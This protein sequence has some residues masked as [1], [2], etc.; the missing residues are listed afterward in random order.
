MLDCF[1]QNFIDRLRNKFGSEF[2]AVVMLFFG[3]FCW[4]AGAS[5]L[6]VIVYTAAFVATLL[7]C[8]DVK[9]IFAFLLFVP[10]FISDFSKADS[11]WSVYIPC[12]AAG[13]VS[14]IAFFALK[15]VKERKNIKKGGLFYP[16]IAFTAAMLI[17]GLVGRFNAL[18]FFA[19]FGLSV[20]TLLFYI[21]AI[22]YTENLS[23]FF[24]KIF[25]I[26][27]L[28]IALE[29][30]S[31]H[32]LRHEPWGT[33]NDFGVFFFSAESFNT[34]SIYITIGMAG[35]FYLGAGKKTD[36]RYAALSIFLFL[37]VVFGRCRMMTLVAAICLAAE[38]V[39]FIVYSEK[40]IRFLWLTIFVAVVFATVCVIFYEKLSEIVHEFITKGHKGI[41]GRDG[42]WSWCS[43]KFKEYPYFGY[44]YF[45][46]EKVPSVRG[47]IVQLV[48]AHN[49]VLQWLTSTGVVGT[50]IAAYFYCGKYY[51]LF[52]GFNKNRIFH[53]LSVLIIAASG[54]TD[55]AATMDIFVIIAAFIF[56]AAAEKNEPLKR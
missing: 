15:A 33:K 1:E 27:S 2:T 29:M 21:I 9:N 4:I 22:N 49:T 35:C 28:L 10:Y 32:V 18:A 19:I 50:S 31:A 30:V 17:G 52:R 12:I 37:C 41:N 20:M 26:G 40:K 53:L 42:L 24:A 6:L 43:E 38:Y 46:E 47:T 36:C 13:A 16:W 39:L 44:G 56:I 3:S 8:K 7:L 34:A 5:E 55:Q 11:I 25:I 23:L 14:V 45:S 48:L 54:I 51:T